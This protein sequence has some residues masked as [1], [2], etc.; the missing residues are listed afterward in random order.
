M[1]SSAYRVERVDSKSVKES[2]GDYDLEQHIIE[3]NDGVILSLLRIKREENCDAPP[4]VLVHG[5][6]S[7][8]RFWITEKGKG[9]APYLYNHGFDVW[10]VE[11]RGHGY[12]KN[13]DISSE[14]IADDVIEHDL[15]A[16]SNYISTINSKLQNWVT[17]SYGGLYLIGALSRFSNI[18]AK[19]NSVVMF[20][21]QLDFGQKYLKIP[22]ISWALKKTTSLIGNFPAQKLGMGTENEPPGIMNQI[23]EW[24]SSKGWVSKSGYHYKSGLHKVT[25]PILSITCLGDKIDPWQG[26]EK[27]IDTIGSDTKL[28]W[29]LSKS[30]G[31]KDDYGHAEMVVSKKA[32]EFVWPK[33][34]EWIINN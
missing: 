34:V 30:N 8:R 11:S 24:K 18:Q 21:T 29:N 13:S 17:H 5:T 28:F 6:Y 15:P 3:A 31:W 19:T 23:F 32:Q 22:V 20:G 16:I 7:N 12:S 26:C 33:V 2:C 14:F 25:A 10:I 4:A 9:F 27:F 1:T